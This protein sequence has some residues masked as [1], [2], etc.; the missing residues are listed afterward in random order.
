DEKYKQHEHLFFGEWAHITPV[1]EII[2]PVTRVVVRYKY[3]DLPLIAA[4]DRFTGKTLPHD[5]LQEVG[6]R[7]GMPVVERIPSTDME[8]LLRRVEELD[9]NHEGFVL[10]WITENGEAYRVK[11]KGE[12]YKRLHRILS[13]VT[14]RVVAEH[15]LDGTSE[16]LVRE[17]PEEFRLETEQT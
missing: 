15:W 8:A 2:H 7:T 10:L 4:R 3:Q 6:A 5:F 1:I 11:C 16:E 17:M 9:D 12:Q 14:P 13:D